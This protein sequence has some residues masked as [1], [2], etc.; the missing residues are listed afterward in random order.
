MLSVIKNQVIEEVYTKDKQKQ[1]LYGFSNVGT[2]LK[3]AEALKILFICL[4]HPKDKQGL[5]L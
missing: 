3:P 2:R 5:V 4:R 1:S